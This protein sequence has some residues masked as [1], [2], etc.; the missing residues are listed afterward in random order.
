MLNMR[1]N[2]IIMFFTYRHKHLSS[3]FFIQLCYTGTKTIHRVLP[4]K[5]VKKIKPLT[6]SRASSQSN[7]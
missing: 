5:L 7:V 3:L 1:N 6:C 2:L 4:K